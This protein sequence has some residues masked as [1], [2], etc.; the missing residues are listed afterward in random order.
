LN[1]GK[2]LRTTNSRTKRS[3]LPTVAAKPYKSGVVAFSA[4][5]FMQL[6]AKNN[7][8]RHNTQKLHQELGSYF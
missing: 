8:L 2:T 7:L 6:G 4:Y 5:G 3:Q 1:Y